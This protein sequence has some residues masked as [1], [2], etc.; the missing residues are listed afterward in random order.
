MCVIETTPQLQTRRLMLRA[1]R[2]TDI[3][4]ILA[5]CGDPDVARM[6]ATLPHPYERADAQAFLDRA[7]FVDPRRE[8]MLLIE[9]EDHGAIGIIGLHPG[10]GPLPELGYVVGRPYWGRGF[11]TEAVEAA[12]VWAARGWGR[13]AVLAGHF[14]DNPA[15]GRVLEKAGFLYTGEVRAMACRARGAEVQVRRMAWLA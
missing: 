1:P 6:T 12:L 15:S 10:P 14:A 9:H 8:L 4:Q 5:L 2:P 3:D 11:A 13:R 7:A